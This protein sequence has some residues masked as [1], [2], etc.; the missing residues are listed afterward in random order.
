MSTESVRKRLDKAHRLANK[1][2]EWERKIV[3]WL[4]TTP[5]PD[6]LAISR[7]SADFEHHAPD[8]LRLALD[9]IEAAKEFADWK[10]VDNTPP[11]PIPPPPCGWCRAC[12]LRKALDAFE[13]AP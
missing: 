12:V 10:C 2:H 5:F 6:G 3:P 4:V 8:D 7:A 11:R 9:V 13:A 1:H